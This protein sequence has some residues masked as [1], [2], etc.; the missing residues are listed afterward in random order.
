MSSTARRRSFSA[1]APKVTVQNSEA[2]VVILLKVYDR[3]VFLLC[4]KSAYVSMYLKSNQ[5][6]AKGLHLATDIILRILLILVVPC[7]FY[8]SGLPTS[9]VLSHFLRSKEH[10]KQPALNTSLEPHSLLVAKFTH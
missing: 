7:R 9:S 10:T 5:T 4:R 2:V 8:F 3:E 6:D 1:C